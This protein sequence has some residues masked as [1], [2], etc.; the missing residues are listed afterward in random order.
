MFKKI[1][2][3]VIVFITSTISNAQ[4]AKVDLEKLESLTNS[5]DARETDNGT[6]TCIVNTDKTV[7]TLKK[8]EQIK[9][10][11]NSNTDAENELI[12]RALLEDL[13]NEIKN[14]N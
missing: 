1:L 10:L 12:K 8:F 14:K 3:T 13:I 11:L 5:A 6:G 2:S 9:V 4:V 7:N